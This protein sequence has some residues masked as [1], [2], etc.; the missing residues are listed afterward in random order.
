[1]DQFRRKAASLTKPL[2][3]IPPTQ[4]LGLSSAPLGRIVFKTPMGP[5]DLVA[6][7]EGLCGVQFQPQ[8]FEH[9]NDCP[10]R[11]RAILDQTKKQLD[12]YFCGKRRHFTLRLAH[13]T[14]RLHE[15]LERELSGLNYGQICSYRE[16][17]RRLGR[18]Q[19]ARVIGNA[20]GRNPLCIV[21][22]CH[23][24]IRTDGSLGGYVGGPEI[25]ARLL[26]LEHKGLP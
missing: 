2:G 16:L 1:M 18:P 12:E 19:A 11:V 22:P 21:I 3:T 10:P 8:E 7:V 6:S 14:G 4:T 17:A 23:R 24:V 20:L 9:Y 26:Q 5:L 15:S 13:R 25:K